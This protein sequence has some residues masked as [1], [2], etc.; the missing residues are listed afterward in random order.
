MPSSHVNAVPPHPSFWSDPS[1]KGKSAP[2]GR[3]CLSLESESIGW[4]CSA[5]SSWS[6]V[7]PVRAVICDREKPFSSWGPGSARWWKI[8]SHKQWWPT[9]SQ[10]RLEWRT[11]V[12]PPSSVTHGSWVSDTLP[13]VELTALGG[14]CTLLLEVWVIE[15]WSSLNALFSIWGIIQAV[16]EL[17]HSYPAM[18]FFVLLFRL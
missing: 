18:M 15:Y 8:N 17:H 4:C 6:W 12:P 13:G 7:I 16:S 10:L 9:A 1:V 14:T 3:G 11:G 5:C 2:G